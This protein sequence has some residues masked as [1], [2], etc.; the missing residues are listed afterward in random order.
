MKK[1]G[2]DARL[3]F[4]TGV[5]TYLQNLLYYL[6]ESKP[7]NIIYYVYFLKKDFYKVSFR[8]KNLVKRLADYKWHSITE[9][10]GFLKTL[11]DDNLDLM[12]FT[13]FSYPILYF[14]KF[15][16]TVHD[17]TPLVYKTG[18]SSTKNLFIYWTK[19]LVFRL[20][21]WL[22]VFRS[23]IITT[24]TNTVKKELI[25][26]YGN[27]IS[28]KIIVLYEGLNYKILVT[29][30][31]KKLA[32]KY[33]NFFIYV[34]NFYPHKN[35]DNLIEAISKIGPKIKLL[36]IGPDDYFARKLKLKKNIILIKNPPL[37]D[38]IYYYKNAMAIIHP[39]LSEGF[40][41]P[42]I[43][44]AYFKTP[45]IASNIEVFRELW[46][47]NYINFNPRSTD[48][49]AKKISEFINNPVKFEY[50][51]LEDKFSFSKMTK[52]L[53]KIYQSVTQNS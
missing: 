1:I 2:I 44:A 22:Q 39:S 12:H 25:N 34:G 30:E 52:S 36:L 53:I 33:G 41:L 47:K 13:Y 27:K 7:K 20:T 35:V 48:E 29:K 6:D 37:S 43:E 31:N 16:S 40:G 9:Q 19:H 26:V 45:I 38:L 23:K 15:I 14:R 46:D 10:I 11:L 4:Q 5:G 32:G 42:L 3:Y 49:I 8:S 24:P 51:N 17:I 18:K 50:Q 28:K 21:L